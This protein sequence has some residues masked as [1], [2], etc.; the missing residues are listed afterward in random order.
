MILHLLAVWLLLNALFFVW[1]TPARSAS[2]FSK[3]SA[4]RD[5]A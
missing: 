5:R 3:S 2:E 4:S 1:M